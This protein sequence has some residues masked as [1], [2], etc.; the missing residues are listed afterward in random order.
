MFR[1]HLVCLTKKNFL[2]LSR[3]YKA[4]FLEIFTCVLCII[5]LVI[6]RKT[7]EKIFEDEKSYLENDQKTMFPTVMIP[8]IDLFF[9]LLKRTSAKK[10]QAFPFETCNFL[11][12]MY[13]LL[14]Y[15]VLKESIKKSYFTYIYI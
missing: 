14:I 6:L 5:A 15:V 3:N 10:G 1:K 7:T 8:N 12:N 9:Q 4:L 13:F 2:L 11:K